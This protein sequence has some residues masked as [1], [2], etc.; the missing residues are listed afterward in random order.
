MHGDDHVHQKSLGIKCWET[1]FICTATKPRLLG[2]T[3]CEGRCYKRSQPFSLHC[4]LLFCL[5]PRRL[6]LSSTAHCRQSSLKCRWLP[7]QSSRKGLITTI[8]SKQRL[9][10]QRKSRK[11]GLLKHWKNVERAKAS[12]CLHERIKVGVN[13]VRHI[14]SDGCVLY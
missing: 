5:C 1:T 8:E 6:V 13:H 3:R 12:R 2:R 11:A 9:L 14:S 10:M 4:Y 7:L